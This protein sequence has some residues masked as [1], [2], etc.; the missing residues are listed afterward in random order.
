MKILIIGVNGKMGKRVAEICKKQ[1]IDFA[2]VDIKEQSCKQQFD[3]ECAN[4]SVAIDF[5]SPDALEKNLEF[6]VKN[7]INIVVA[8]TGHSDKNMQLIQSA[9][10]QIAIFVC[11]NL[12]VGFYRFILATQKL[13]CKNYD[14]AIIEQHHKH[15]KDN[16][17]GSAKQIQK[18]LDKNHTSIQT[19]GIR[20]GEEI[21]SHSVVFLGEYEKITITHQ[22]NSRDVFAQGAIDVAKF[23]MS[24]RKGFF[25]MKDYFENEK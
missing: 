19:F 16:P 9:K 25:E 17:S 13:D 11:P 10:K 23:L 4:C 12:S 2:G 20:G 8:T 24:K 21:G 1:N 5:S 22:A 6:C 3:A 15:K 14:V 7:K 18:T